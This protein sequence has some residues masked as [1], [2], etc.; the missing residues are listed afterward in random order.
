MSHILIEF[1]R[2]SDER[3]GAERDL[4]LL[5]EGKLFWINI[6]LLFQEIET[7]G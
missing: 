2:R 3:V 4:L 6:I 5:G 7:L 1:G